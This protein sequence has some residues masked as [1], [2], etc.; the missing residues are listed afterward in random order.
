MDGSSRA[1]VVKYAANRIKSP[2]SLAIDKEDN[3]LIW[4]D[5]ELDQIESVSL[6][7]TGESKMLISSTKE[8]PV[9]VDVDDQYVYYIGNGQRTAKRIRK[10]DGTSAS[11]IFTSVLFGRLT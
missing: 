4:S 7:N 2:S 3:R 1:S 9:A 10:R 5:S 8:F 6:N 11:V